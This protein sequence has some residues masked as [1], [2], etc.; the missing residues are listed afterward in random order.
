MHCYFFTIVIINQL[1]LTNVA[2]YI[3]L[4]INSRSA[5]SRVIFSVIPGFMIMTV[6]CDVKNLYS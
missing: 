2:F 5:E 4:V 6:E 1:T 3:C